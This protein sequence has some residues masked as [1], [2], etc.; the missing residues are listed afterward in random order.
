MPTNDR[1]HRG[2]TVPRPHGTA[3]V[4]T[5]DRP[6]TTLQFMNMLDMFM[7]GSD[8]P[9][10]P[11]RVPAPDGPEDGPDP[12]HD[13]TTDSGTEEG[14]APMF[15]DAMPLLDGPCCPCGAAAERLGELCRKCR[16]RNRWAARTAQRR[17]HGGRS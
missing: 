12:Y 16:S 17:Q 5:Q 2:H 6:S 14:T 7:S 15:A 11:D 9:E 1:L 4:L 3:A 13:P 10:G 8:L